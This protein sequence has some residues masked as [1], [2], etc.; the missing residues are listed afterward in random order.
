MLREWSMRSDAAAGGAGAARPIALAG[1]HEAPTAW[2]G[3]ATAGT[4][5][6]PAWPASGP[7]GLEGQPLVELLRAV[8]AAGF[9]AGRRAGQD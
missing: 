9:E 2:A 4:P 7:A 3:P 1:V 8:W 5:A 6:G